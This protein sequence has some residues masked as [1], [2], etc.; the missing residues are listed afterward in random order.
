MMLAAHRILHRDH[1]RL[2]RAKLLIELGLDGLDAGR[3]LLLP[4][5]VIGGM[6]LGAEHTI[7]Q[8]VDLV[9][10]FG[11]EVR[12][13]RSQM[14]GGA[15]QFDDPVLC[16][17][18]LSRGVIRFLGDRAQ[19]FDLDGRGLLQ[20]GDLG[21]EAL[22]GKGGGGRPDMAQGGGPDGGKADAALDAVRQALAG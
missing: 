17:V 4:A 9:L 11:L 18:D 20:P 8:P 2:H 21:V 14:R 7:G 12:E 1:V 5:A 3:R 6:Q 10:L 19:P 13:L 22:G 16:A 15:L